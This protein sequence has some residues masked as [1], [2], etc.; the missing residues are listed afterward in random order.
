M[1]PNYALLMIWFC[2]FSLTHDWLYRLHNR[3][4]RFSTETFDALIMLI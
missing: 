4:F 2:V 1:L 3:W